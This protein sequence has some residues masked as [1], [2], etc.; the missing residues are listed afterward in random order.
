MRHGD[1]PRL[2]FSRNERNGN[3]LGNGTRSECKKTNWWQWK[4]RQLSYYYIRY[5]LRDT[6]SLYNCYQFI[7]IN[8]EIS[9]CGHFHF[10]GNPN[11]GGSCGGVELKGA[12]YTAIRIIGNNSG[13]VSMSFCFY[14]EPALLCNSKP[15]NR[16]PIV[17][18]W[19]SSQW[20][21]GNEYYL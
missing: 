16:R 7:R 21:V 1:M 3:G 13:V 20:S 12:Y 8:H 11:V 9:I 19:L 15:I 10:N 6:V 2:N 4:E 5:E 14:A 17:I 18:V